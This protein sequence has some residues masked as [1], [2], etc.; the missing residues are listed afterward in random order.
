MILFNLTTGYGFISTGNFQGLQTDADRTRNVRNLTG[1][2]DIFWL[3]G[4]GN[5]LVKLS[6]SHANPH[7]VLQEL[8]GTATDAGLLLL[9]QGLPTECVHAVRE[10][11]LD[12]GIV[13]SQ[14]V[15]EAKLWACLGCI[16]PD[17]KAIT[18][19]VAQF[20]HIGKLADI[21]ATNLPF[22]TVFTSLWW[23]VILV[24][25]ITSIHYHI[26]FLHKIELHCT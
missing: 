15:E 21:R 26:I 20:N 9:V 12:Q 14:T 13:H 23:R 22:L 16:S 7:R 25:N 3:V 11:P 5:A 10:A 6:E 19:M 18:E 8:L 24:C 1:Q 2:G 4:C 17:L